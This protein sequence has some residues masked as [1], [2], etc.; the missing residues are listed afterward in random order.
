MSKQ[1]RKSKMEIEIKKKNRALIGSWFKHAP[2]RFLGSKKNTRSTIDCQN[3]KVERWKSKS[4]S[5]ARTATIRLVLLAST[6]T[7]GYHIRT[8]VHS[9]QPTARTATQPHTS[10]VNSQQA[11]HNNIPDAP[12]PLLPG[13]R[14]KAKRTGDEFTMPSRTRL[15]VRSQYNLKFDP[16]ASTRHH[17]HG[18]PN[19]LP[20]SKCRRLCLLLWWICVAER[21]VDVDCRHVVHSF[22]RPVGCS[23]PLFFWLHF[24][25]HVLILFGHCV[26]ITL[27]DGFDFDVRFPVSILFGHALNLDCPDNSNQWTLSESSCPNNFNSCTVHHPKSIVQAKFQLIQPVKKKFRTIPINTQSPRSFVWTIPIDWKHQTS[28]VQAIPINA[29]SLKSI[30]RTIPINRETPK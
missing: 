13:V 19:D 1:D 21:Y 28:I 17:L 18:R 22:G 5:K 26:E 12:G 23:S 11:N 8:A 24:S 7:S 27:E 25:F 9:T 15:E 6:A 3:Q 4:N 29:Q 10:P 20:G 16:G 14:A 2:L 30:V